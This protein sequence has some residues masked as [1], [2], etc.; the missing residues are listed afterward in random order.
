[1]SA[2][3]R[4]ARRT[5]IGLALVSGA[6]LMGQEAKPTRPDAVE[7]AQSPPR[8]SGSRPEQ[9]KSEHDRSD[10]FA[11]DNAPPSS[12]AFKTQPDEGKVKGFDFY[13]DPLNA[14]RP[15]QTFEET[16]QQDV[17]DKPKVMAAQRA[18]H[19]RSVLPADRGR[20]RQPR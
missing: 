2:Q 9:Q 16:M 7:E 6:A 5:A 17:A 4:R 1:M 10:V 12:E 19:R 15:M 3:F 8:A 18:L 13:R 14:K 11:A 20:V